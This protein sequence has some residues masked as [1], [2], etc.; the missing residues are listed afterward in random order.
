[1]LYYITSK[2]VAKDSDMKFVHFITVQ[3][4]RFWRFAGL[5]QPLPLR[6]IHLLVVFFVFFELISISLKDAY[7]GAIFYHKLGG[8]VLCF[9]III[10]LAYCFK[11]RGIKYYYPYLWGDFVQLKSDIAQSLKFKIVPLRPRGLAAAVRGLGFVAL[12]LTLS[13]GA[14]TALLWKLGSAYVG[15]AFEIHAASASLL[16]VYLICH[17]GMAL[18]RFVIWERKVFKG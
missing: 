8:G 11:L 12:A 14:L 3:S 16:V 10:M 15:V 13:F 4:A 2:F 5:F 17:G 6:I 7:P 1:M 9:L 18:A